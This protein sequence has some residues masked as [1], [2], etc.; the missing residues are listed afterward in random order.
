LILRIGSAASPLGEV[1]DAIGCRGR[2]KEFGDSVGPADL[3]EVEMGLG[4]ESEVEAEIA[5]GVV[6]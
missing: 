1:E 6:A 4:P 5:G 2:F 3:D